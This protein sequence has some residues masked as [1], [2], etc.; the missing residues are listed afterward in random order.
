[1]RRIWAFLKN[2]VAGALFLLGLAALSGCGG[3]RGF[4]PGQI[5][6]IQPGMA[7]LQVT[8]RIGPPRYVNTG[9]NERAGR[10]EWVYPK[11]YLIIY[12]S[13]VRFVVPVDDPADLPPHNPGQDTIGSMSP[14]L[15]RFDDDDI[16]YRQ[17]RER[18]ANARPGRK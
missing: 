10:D 18:Q 4:F 11:G 13:A 6:R 17:A 8:E 14:M 12:R 5:D 16:Y 9:E 15:N 3:D 2:A 1:M 7:T